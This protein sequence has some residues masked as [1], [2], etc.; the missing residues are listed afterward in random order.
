MYPPRKQPLAPVTATVEAA[1]SEPKAVLTAPLIEQEPAEGS[2]HLPQ[3][4]NNTDVSTVEP[5]PPI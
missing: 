1:P 3:P 2:P 5:A 4:G